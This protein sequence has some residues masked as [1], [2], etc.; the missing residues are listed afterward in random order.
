MSKLVTAAALALALA[1]TPA[2]A[3]EPFLGLRVG[4]GIPFGKIAPAN[5]IRD[6]ISSNVPLQVDAGFRF[7]QP[8]SLGAYLSYGFGLLAGETD[9]AC[10]SADCSERTFRIGVQAAVHSA[11]G[12]GR[13]MW[14]GVL[15]GWERLHLEAPAD[16]TASGAELGL[17]GGLDFTGTGSGFGPFGSLTFGRFSSLEV[18]GRDVGIADEKTHGTLQVGVRGYFG[19]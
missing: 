16:V 7:G 12:S 5:D 11:V 14:G 1:S 18:G 17:Q 19:L 9:A 6:V 3:V 15:L 13:E 10:G 8:F 2:S 4:F